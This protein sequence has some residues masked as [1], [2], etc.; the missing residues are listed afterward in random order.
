[1]ST[2]KAKRVL[3]TDEEIEPPVYEQG[4]NIG[5]NISAALDCEHLDADL[6]RS[7]M[8][9]WKP[10]RARGVFGGQ[11][12]GQAVTVS[13][14]SVRDDVR[15]HSLHCYFLLAG[16]ETMPIYYHVSRLRDGGSY[17]TRLVEAKQKGKCIFVLFT[18]Y[19]KPEPH[20][21][22]FA[23]PLPGAISHEGSAGMGGNPEDSRPASSSSTTSP[24]P[25]SNSFSPASMGMQVG[26]SS[27]ESRFS[28][29]RATSG[30]VQGLIPYEKAE[31]N[32]ARYLRVLHDLE[33]VLPQKAKDGLRDWI[34]DR[35]ESSIEVR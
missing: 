34:R 33:D 4:T 6:F 31:L 2:A 25:A 15:L 10:A 22:R 3:P 21:P 11:V 5:P 32:E 29:A 27:I 19:A 17:I 20:R 23:I 26:G 35:V 12:I 8:P 18:S 1:M 13:N 7:K 30:V 14:R 9:L 16:D 28:M 24:S